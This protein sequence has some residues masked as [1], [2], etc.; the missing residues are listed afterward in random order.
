MLGSGLAH[1]YVALG[2]LLLAFGRSFLYRYLAAH[3]NGDGLVVDLVDHRI[4]QV[5]RF[6]LVDQ[7]R[8][9]LFVA[10]VLYGVLQ[11]VQLAEVLFPGLV[12]DMQQDALLE[13]LHHFLAFA[14]I[15]G[16]QIAG[17]VVHAL[18]VSDGNQDVLVHV[19]LVLVYLLDD[20]IGN[21]CH[22]VGLALEE[23]HCGIESLVGQLFFFLFL[24][25]VFGERGF[26]G[27]CLEHV[28]LAVLVVGSLY[29]IDT[30]VPNHVHDVHADAFAHQ[31]V[32]AFGVDH[33]TLLVH[34]VVVFQQAFTDAE[35]VFF[36]FLLGPFDGLG[37]HAVFN[38]FTFLEAQLVHHAG[39]AVGREQTHQ[40]VFQ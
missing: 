15:G 33:G 25:F 14:F 18:A 37:N 4:E 29:G 10:G 39:N 35:V 5:D 20:R 26:H 28:H 23:L 22:A 21:L 3:Q 6:E 16:F 11:V 30:A 7:Q 1:F 34:H 8:V 38:H 32:A 12:D 9:F 17:N 19:S 31:G 24:E 36:H 2:R 13:R 40:V 27:Q